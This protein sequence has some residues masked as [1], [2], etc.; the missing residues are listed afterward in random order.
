VVIIAVVT[1]LLLDHLHLVTTKLLDSIATVIIA[2]PKHLVITEQQL[3][4]AIEI[5]QHLRAEVDLMQ[6][7]IAIVAHLHLQILSRRDN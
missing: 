5:L 3:A 6:Q 7:S 4:I 2:I 1:S